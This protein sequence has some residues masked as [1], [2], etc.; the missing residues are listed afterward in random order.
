MDTFSASN[1]SLLIDPA[2]TFNSSNIS[3]QAD[4]IDLFNK[5]S[6]VTPLWSQTFRGRNLITGAVGT[7]LNCLTLVAVIRHDDLTRSLRTALVS[8]VSTDLG[9]MLT[10]LI[11][12][13]LYKPGDLVVSVLMH[14]FYVFLDCTALTL[15]VIAADRALAVY[16]PVWYRAYCERWL[17]ILTGILSPWV[18]AIFFTVVSLQTS[19][20][21]GLPRLPISRLTDTGV[22]VQ[23]LL[24]LISGLGVLVAYVAMGCRLKRRASRPAVHPSC[25]PRTVRASTTSVVGQRA[26]R[27]TV[28]TLF[29]AAWFCIIYIPFSCYFLLL[30]FTGSDRAAEINSPRNVVMST[31]I[32][33]NSIVNPVIFFWRL[34]YFRHAISCCSRL[35]FRRTA[36]LNT[37]QDNHSRDIGLSVPPSGVS[38]SIC[39][40]RITVESS[41]ARYR[42][43]SASDPSGHSCS[44]HVEIEVAEVSCTFR[45]AQTQV[46]QTQRRME[47]S[48]ISGHTIT[49]VEN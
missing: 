26:R 28:H 41:E 11:G 37:D 46:S 19:H 9:L 39:V 24:L 1:N 22:L 20:T 7:V 16:L 47:I 38:Q 40:Q 43:S 23:G 36:D 12:S 29:L 8:L 14:L 48:T 10:V 17:K 13:L 15:T 49:P 4:D 33:V 30:Y 31:F 27:T 6:D 2:D 32:I 5:S 42:D 44:G 21:R 25:T 45:R 35:L 34:V 18:L 3:L